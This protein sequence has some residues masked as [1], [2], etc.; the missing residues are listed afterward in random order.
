MSHVPAVSV[1]LTAYNSSDFIADSIQSVLDQSFQ[2]FELIVVDDGST[3]HTWSLVNSFDNE[4]IRP[5]QKENG[6]AAAG[7]NFGIEQARSGLIAILDSDDLAHPTRLEKQVEF[8]HKQADHVCVGSQARA[9]DTDGDFIYN[10]EVPL[11]D[12]EIKKHL[13]DMP[14]VHPSI[15]FRKEAFKKVGGYFEYMP[16]AEDRVM[17]N[18][19][20]VHGLMAN[21]EEELIDYRIVP[22]SSSSRNKKDIT[23]F[24]LIITHAIEND[25][26]NKEQEEYMHQRM[27][28]RSLTSKR[29][30]Y[31]VFIG[32][33]YL[34]NSFITSKA[35]KNFIQAIQI[36]PY[37]LTSY[38][39]LFMTILPSKWVKYAYTRLKGANR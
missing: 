6:G 12:T 24:E 1:I 35:R 7:R 29:F 4:Q 3:D 10:I 21:L 22:G 13:P 15:M 33:K 25:S 5:F 11:N 2:D 32:K 30:D 28:G 18:K 36:K 14:F 34:W 37:V 27:K 39:F 26:I 17:L 38:I 20:S 31:H 19:L 16:L 23:K 9:V 8:M